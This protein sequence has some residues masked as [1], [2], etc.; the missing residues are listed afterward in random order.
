MDGTVFGFGVAGGV[1]TASG[2][3]FFLGQ[4]GRLAEL[5]LI[6]TSVALTR[7]AIKFKRAC[8]MVRATSSATV[9]LLDDSVDALITGVVSKHKDKSVAVE[10]SSQQKKTG[11]QVAAVSSTVTRHAGTGVGG[12]ET[13]PRT[14]LDE[15]TT[16][17]IHDG[18]GAVICPQHTFSSNSDIPKTDVAHERWESEQG[19]FGSVE[20]KK[21]AS[22]KQS[23]ERGASEVGYDVREETLPF[24]A[25]VTLHGRVRLADDEHSLILERPA[26]LTQ[27]SR[28]AI[29]SQQVLRTQRKK[30]LSVALLL[31]GVACVGYAV[32]RHNQNRRRMRKRR[33]HSRDLDEEDEEDEVD[34]DDQDDDSDHSRERRDRIVSRGRDAVRVASGRRHHWQPSAAHQ[35]EPIPVAVLGGAE[36]EGEYVVGGGAHRTHEAV[37]GMKPSGDDN[38]IICLTAPKNAVLVPCGHQSMCHDCALKWLFANRN[39]QC[40]ICRQRVKRVQK[41]FRT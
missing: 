2:I 3:Y 12:P 24:G 4:Q 23:L 22:F 11:G 14:H 20:V 41:I 10:T 15:W 18:S 29:L 9:A 7:Q 1:L 6:P 5:A 27:D 40:P 13:Q 8:N 35:M 38:C 32:F 25:T 17:E 31:S 34:T 26:V 21:I 36:Y 30:W 16:F 39:R 19:W 37:Q 28:A 33:S